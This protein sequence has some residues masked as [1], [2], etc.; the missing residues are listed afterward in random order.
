M[1]QQNAQETYSYDDEAE[2]EAARKVRVDQKMDVLVGSL[3][4]LANEQVT[5]K[6]N[7]EDRWLLDFMQFNGKYESSVLAKLSAA[8][9]SQIFVNYTRNKSNGWEARLSDML[10]PTDD[11]NWGIKPTPSPELAMALKDGDQTAGEIQKE[12][13]KRAASMEREIEDQLR[14]SHYNIEARDAIHDSCVLGTGIMKGPTTA[15]RNRRKWQQTD[16]G[17]ELVEV[18][19]IRPDW[20]RVDPWNYF[21]D[22]NARKKDDCEFEFERHLLNKK[23]MRKMA[24]QPGFNKDAI[25]EIMKEEP[26]FG[27]PSYIQQIKSVVDDGQSLEAKYHV[28]EYHGPIDG[29]D[30]RNL[31][32]ALGDENLAEGIDE[33]DPLAEV[34]VI[35]WFCQNKIIKIGEHPLDSGDSM[36]S[37]FNL[38]G[39]DSS[40][41]GFG[42]PYLMRDSQK[43]LNGAWR[44][45]MDNSALST[46]PQIVVNTDIIEPMDGNWNLTARKVWKARLRNGQGLDHAFKAYNIDGHQSELIQVISLAKQFADDETNLPLIAQGESG[47][48]QTQTSGGMSMLMNSVNVVFRRVVKN[49]DD[50][51]TTKNIRRQYDF[52]MQFSDKDEIKGDFE[53]DAR[54]SSVLLVREVQAQNLMAIALQF[55]GHPQLGPLTK[56]PELYRSLI[57]AHMLPADSIVKTDEELEQEAAAKAEQ[58]PE[59]DIEM[60]KLQ[61]KMDVVTKQGEM[62]I[63]VAEMDRDTAMMKLAEQR[64]MQLEELQTRLGIAES[65]SSS[66]ER[67]FAGELGLKEK[68]GEGI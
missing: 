45:I 47:G 32:E 39:D 6:S 65:N 55:S 59:P 49:F 21:P 62:S 11:K 30:L 3:Q 46:G 53:V 9:K 66:K 10:F 60:L 28:W 40:V 37:V 17:Q 2:T 20:N 34:L 38:E 57:Q 67:M 26:R 16:A 12:A 54:G 58:P 41:F 18:P 27:M 33:N 35:A 15:S 52:N 29:D 51:V 36:Y 56:T 7:I 14:E 13:I 4:K 50:D 68:T 8:A 19:D 48:H 1:A 5:K 24:N 44:M 43:S 61:A 22:M 64:N 23:Q 31:A 25:R 63:A 42:V